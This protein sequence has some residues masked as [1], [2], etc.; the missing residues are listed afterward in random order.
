[1]ER[2]CKPLGYTWNLQLKIF[3]ITTIAMMVIV[4]GFA[5]FIK[6]PLPMILGLVFGTFIS[7]LNFR[8]LALTLEKA[9]CM[10]PR[11]AQVYASSRYFIRFIINGIVIFIGIKADYLNVVGVII[12]LVMIKVVILATNLFND[13]S[14]FKRIFIRKEEE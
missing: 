8:T 2:K 9:V 10:A 4:V 7:M 13:K 12:G 6:N 3:K 11:Q 5:V 14:Y 1:M